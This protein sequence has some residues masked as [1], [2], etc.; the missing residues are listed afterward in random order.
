LAGVRGISATA[1]DADEW[2]AT[3]WP[4]SGL[5]RQAM[6][7]ARAAAIAPASI[8][9]RAPCAVTATGSWLTAT[10]IAGSPAAP[11]AAPTWRLVLMTP[12]TT[13]WSAPAIPVVAMTIVPKAV[14]AVPKPTS[15]TAASSG[16]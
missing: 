8:A 16:L 3:A 1:A 6:I 7:A 12:P 2:C 5:L 13:P 15:M 14:P 10:A 4:D 9:A 11:R